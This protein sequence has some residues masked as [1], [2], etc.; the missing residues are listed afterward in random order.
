[1]VIFIDNM[2]TSKWDAFTNQNENQK[3]KLTTPGQTRSSLCD[4]RRE[5]QDFFYKY[6]VWQLY[7][8]NKISVTI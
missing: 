8:L 5:V 7:W 3:V 4:V 1:M 2:L 6:L